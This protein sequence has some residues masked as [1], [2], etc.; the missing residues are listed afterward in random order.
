MNVGDLIHAL[1]THPADA[2]VLYLG[3]YVRLEITKFVVFNDPK[4]VQITGVEP[5]PIDFCVPADGER[6]DQRQVVYL[7]PDL[8]DP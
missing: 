1:S 7:A 4:V 8:P 6:P 3:P 5:Q 2:E